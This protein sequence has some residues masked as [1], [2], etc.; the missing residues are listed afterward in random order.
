MAIANSVWGVSYLAD[1]HT[2]THTN[3]SH[4]TKGWEYCLP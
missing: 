2:H 3:L 4:K 1:T